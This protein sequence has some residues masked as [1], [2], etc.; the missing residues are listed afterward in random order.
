MTHDKSPVLTRIETAS[1]LDI[2][3]QTLRTWRVRGFLLPLVD[4]GG[5][6]IGYWRKE[7]EDFKRKQ[8]QLL[9][10]RKPGPKKAGAAV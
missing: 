9:Q 2:S 10:R 3:N 1:F 5:K 6:T 4:S 8:R 7:C